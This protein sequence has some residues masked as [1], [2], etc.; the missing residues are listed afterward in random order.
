MV[1][2]N[3]HKKQFCNVFLFAFFS[4]FLY[5]PVMKILIL[6]SKFAYGG[7][8]RV[9]LNLATEWR[10]A[11]ADVT[12]T[13]LSSEQYDA[14]S[15]P[16]GIRHISLNIPGHPNSILSILRNNVAPIF[17][18]RRLLRRERPDIVIGSI[19][20]SV[21]ILS[22]ACTRDEISIG[23]EH[24]HPPNSFS[25]M[26]AWIWNL[27]R[28]FSYFRLDGV[29]ALTPQSAEWLRKNT[30]ARK[31]VSIPNS[32][33]LPLPDNKPKIEPKDI[34]PANKRLLLAS[35]R[36][37]PHK[38]F[39]RLLDAFAQIA[40]HYPDWHLVILGEG[41]LREDLETQVRLLDLTQ[42]VSLPGF[43]GN[44]ADWYRFADALIITSET[45]GFPMVLL[46]AMAHGCPV[47]S[48]DC[49]VGPRNIIDN[50]ENGLLVAQDTNAIIEALDRMLSDDAL[51]KRL[52]SKAVEVLETYSP[53]RVNAKWQDL[54]DK[55]LQKRRV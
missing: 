13:V 45:E 40:P 22:L 33:S 25:G 10:D 15:I 9:T 21:I 16:D 2:H 38:R 31:I 17:A 1:C 19:N 32:I 3:T 6:L 34:V 14:Y 37:H 55:S 28:R 49:P 44:V 50:G 8:E 35:G 27:I 30:H 4:N 5:F 42:R 23:H 41:D 36:L 54:F 24:G 11:G 46:E 20:I 18:V 29:V 39:D 48:V 26:A 7:A 52:A 43:A 47:I 12:I 53:A 51:R